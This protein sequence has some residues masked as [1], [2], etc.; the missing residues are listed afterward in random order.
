MVRVPASE[1]RGAGGGRLFPEKKERARRPNE[2]YQEER[3]FSKPDFVPTRISGH[4]DGLRGAQ[5]EK[6][7]LLAIDRVQALK[8]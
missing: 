4:A 6:F 3:G 7:R 1:A 5:K 2:L 8:S